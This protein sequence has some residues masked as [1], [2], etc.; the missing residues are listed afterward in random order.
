MH[1]VASETLR[2]AFMLLAKWKMPLLE[3]QLCRLFF[4]CLLS[5]HI[6][7]YRRYPSRKGFAAGELEFCLRPFSHL[8]A[9]LQAGPDRRARAPS[10]LLIYR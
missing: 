10:V 4:C 1:E 7:R 9:V 6:Q 5:N 2:T 8:L 3:W